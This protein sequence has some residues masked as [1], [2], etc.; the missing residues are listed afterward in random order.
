V[1]SNRSRAPGENVSPSR[2]REKKPGHKKRK[3]LALIA[4]KKIREDK[5][6]LDCRKVNT[7]LGGV[8]G[9]TERDFQKKTS[10]GDGLLAHH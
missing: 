7:L 8:V 2:E 4:K 3:R 5:M 10:E 1:E 9:A 6:P